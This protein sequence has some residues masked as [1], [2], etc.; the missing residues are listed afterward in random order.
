M[1]SEPA[2]TIEDVAR[3][4]DAVNDETGYFVP[5]NLNAWSAEFAKHLYPGGPDAAR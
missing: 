4:W 2:P 1:Q 5:P 3:H